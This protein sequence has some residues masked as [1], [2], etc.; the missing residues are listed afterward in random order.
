MK[1][2][3]R[4]GVYLAAVD[5][6]RE[7]H[8]VGV[9][10]LAAVTD[11]LQRVRGAHP[12]DGLFEAADLQWWWRIPRPT[13][14]LAQLFWFDDHD[15]PV[16]AAVATA[17]REHTALD[18]I[19]LRGADP[20]WVAHVV[21]RGVAHAA[22]LGIGTVELEVDRGD[23]V[24]R[25]VLVGHGFA[26]GGDGVVETWLEADAR[27]P[28]SPLADG[29]RLVRRT[30]TGD[31]PHHMIGR[32][33]PGVEARL[34]QTSLYRADLDLLVLDPDDQVAAYGLFWHDPVT[35]IGLVEPMRTEDEHQRR[36]LARH[37]LTAGVDLLARAGARRIK[38]GYEPGNPASGHLYRSV[39][40]VPVRETVLMSGPTTRT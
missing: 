38:I 18:P 13:D 25:E 15:R 22:E 23:T 1:M 36:G 6:I 10:Y 14:D 29:Y 27:P 17:W 31:R 28:V 32:S 34:L 2:S 5:G 35:A 33:G 4:S 19:V 9:E 30:D 12:T 26:A 3:I 40:F 24:L 7:G 16:A 11:L 8:R 39:G 20:E 21:G 37:V